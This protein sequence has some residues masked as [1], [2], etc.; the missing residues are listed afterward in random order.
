[1]DSLL[2]N[3]KAYL[4][5]EIV[6]CNLAIENGKIFKIG[7]EAHMPQ[8]DETTNL[9]N[10]LVLPG[11]I[12]AHVH[13][14]DE[15]KAYKEDFY[16]GT[17]AAAA[18]GVTTVLDMPNNAPVTMSAETLRNRMKIAEKKA[19]VDI[20]F[21]S[22]FPASTDEIA[23]IVAEGAMAFKLFMACQIG[24]LN[25]DDDSALENAFSKVSELNVPVVVHAEDRALL[26]TAEEKLKKRRHH[27]AAAFLE[28]HSENVELKAIERL[29]KLGAKTKARLHICHVTTST[30]LAAVAEAKKAGR[31]VTCEVTPNHLLLSSE[32]FK[33]YGSLFAIMPPLRS[34]NHIEA[35]WRGVTDGWVDIIGSDHAPHTLKEKTAS[36][37]WEVKVGVPGLE[38]TLPLMLTMVHKNRLGLAT[39]VDLLS[40]KPAR[41]FNLTDRGR[42]DKGKRADLV[43]LDF[44]R[45][46]KVDAAKFHSKAK[47][48]PYNGW[49]LQGKPV[50]TFVNGLLTMDEGEI[51]A[52]AGSGEILRRNHA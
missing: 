44:N 19:L 14:R 7:K 46:F 9:R 16:T 10:L 39:M 41:L 27:D 4:N 18:G 34:S 51:L 40:E 52:K 2:S 8:A 32:D 11:L 24:G 21:Y 37:I 13:L 36:S 25:I 26:A 1:M 43:V 23:S 42:I 17:A 22:E 48:S 47:Y 31:A 33:R 35:L 12:D 5:R 50:K 38:T 29:L 3:A 30:G 15:G 28:A 20:G 49:E 45:K 6:D